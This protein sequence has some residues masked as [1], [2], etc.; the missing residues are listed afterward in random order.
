MLPSRSHRP[1]GGGL[2]MRRARSFS[3]QI[4]A[5]APRLIAKAEICYA[6]H[7]NQCLLA[8]AIGLFVVSQI[9]VATVVGPLL[10]R[11]WPIVWRGIGVCLC[12]GVQI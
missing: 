2:S 3:R 12:F 6:R 11:F 9:M 10:A 8:W 5:K 4:E 1:R 7:P